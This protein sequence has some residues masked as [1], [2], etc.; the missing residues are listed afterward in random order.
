VREALANFKADVSE[1]ISTA[2]AIQQIPAPTFAEEERACHIERQFSEAGLSSVEQDAIHNVFGRLAGSDAAPPVVLSAHSDTVFPIGTDLTIRY[3]NGREA[4]RGLIY[5]PGLVDN[6]LGVAGLISLARTLRRFDMQPAADIWFVA[7]V[8]EEGLGNLTGMRAVV[9]RFGQATAYIVVEG[10][11]YGQIF[12]KAV[13][14]RRYR[15]EI[16]CAGGH[17]WGDFGEPSA[18]HVLSRIVAA[19]ELLPVPAEPKT[20]YNVGVIEGGT[21]VNAIAASASCLV[22]LRSTD[23]GA[24]AQLVDALER[25]L[26]KV[27]ARDDVQVTMTEIGRRPPGE[28][29][30]EQ[31]P[32]NWAVDALHGVGCQQVSL[33]AGSTDANLPLSLGLPAICV[34]LANSGNTHRLDEYVDP[35]H[36]PEGLGQLL[37]LTLAAAGFEPS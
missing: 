22:D 25:L 17:S 31:R 3:G 6:A 33:I 34:G 16:T 14:A 7:N 10:G 11:S 12:N 27:S 21:S 32:V 20:S 9:E 13:G 2:V 1:T 5:G 23:P 29:S 24:L 28:I 19:M 35:T 37:L 18:V 26:A 15:I 8:A 30:S 4:G 36:L